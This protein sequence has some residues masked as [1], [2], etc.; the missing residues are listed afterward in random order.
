MSK[1]AS[2]AATAWSTR[3]S[4]WYSSWLHSQA[5]F[6]GHPSR[7]NV[8]RVRTLPYLPRGTTP[9]NPR[10]RSAPARG[11]FADTPALAGPEG[12]ARWPVTIASP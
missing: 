3:T 1:P 9:W 8:R 4:G 2:S 10:M 7:D 11:Y 6:I 12:P 5:N